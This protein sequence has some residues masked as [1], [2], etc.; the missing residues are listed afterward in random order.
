M[1]AITTL[2]SIAYEGSSARVTG[3]V[4]ALSSSARKPRALAGELLGQR[5]LQAGQRL[6]RE[7]VGCRCGR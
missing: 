2:P 1:E 3:S 5:L 6:A 4:K 7:R